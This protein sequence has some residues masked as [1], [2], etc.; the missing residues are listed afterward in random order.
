LSRAL[1]KHNF[2]VLSIDH[3]GPKGVPIL[4]LN[5]VKASERKNLTSLLRTAS[6]HY[7]HFAPPCGTASAAREIQP[8]PP[9]LRSVEF[10]MGLANLAPL[11]QQRL[12]AANLLYEYTCEA[13]EILDSRNIDWSIENPASSLMWVTRPFRRLQRRRK[14]LFAFSFHTCMFLAPRKKDTA[15]WCS[16]PQLRLHIAFHVITAMVTSNGGAFM[17]P[18]GLLLQQLWSVPTTTPWLLAGH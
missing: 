17:A 6:L 13:V 11:Q 7:V 15:L 1:R 3:K 18:K 4:R 10:P 2:Q 16:F 12:D 14:K 5:I 8:G 9:P